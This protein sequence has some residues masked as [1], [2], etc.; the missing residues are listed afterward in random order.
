M[1]NSA[2]MCALLLFCVMQS[3]GQTAAQVASVKVEPTEVTAQIGQPLQFKAVGLDASGKPLDVP[4][5]MWFAAPWDVGSADANGVVRPQAAGLLRVGAKVGDKIGYARVMVQQPAVTKLE[6]SA[7]RLLM[8]AGQHAQVSAIPRTE[9][10]D[11]RADVPVQWK[12][13][14]PSVVSVDAAGLATALRP[15]ETSVHAMADKASASITI[16]VVPQSQETFR[17]SPK[18]R[19]HVRAT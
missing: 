3:N 13:Q 17:L 14:D 9:N 5:T 11:P 8:M 7:T 4:V 16:A 6:M 12:S 2:R 19:R 18:L 10:G 1:R 15:G